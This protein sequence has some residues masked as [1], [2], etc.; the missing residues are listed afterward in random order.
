M[1]RQKVG[2]VGAVDQSRGIVVHQG[3]AAGSNGL[4]DLGH[5]A[6]SIEELEVNG[7]FQQPAEAMTLLDR[8]SDALGREFLVEDL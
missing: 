6:D 3:G 1:T 4:L 7:A 8:I 2:P 5:L